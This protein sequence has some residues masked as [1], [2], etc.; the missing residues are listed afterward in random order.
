MYRVQFFK[1]A[2][3]ENYVKDFID[4]LQAAV[5]EKI[6]VQISYLEDY[7]NRARRPYAA[8]LRDKVYELIISFAHLEVRI[9]YFFD[10]KVIILTHGFL[11]KTQA[12]P[13][14]EIDRAIAIRAAWF[15]GK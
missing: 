15:R 11:K 3:G 12:V 2:R 9:L 6:I 7:G 5:R 13:T 14:V 8:L 4:G 10:E 1:T